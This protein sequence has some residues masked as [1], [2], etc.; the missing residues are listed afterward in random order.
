MKAL[1]LV[2]V[3]LLAGC[4]TYAAVSRHDAPGD[5]PDLDQPVERENGDPAR[6]ATPDDPGSTETWLWAMPYILTRR[7]RGGDG[8]TEAGLEVRVERHRLGAGHDDLDAPT[9]MLS[10]GAGAAQWR[11]GARTI[12]PAAFYAELGLRV[13]AKDAIPVEIG[14]GPVAYV[15]DPDVGGQIT[16]R[17]LLLIPVRIRYMVHSGAEVMVGFQLPVPFFFGSSR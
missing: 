1:I 16:L 3:A 6:H 15:A 10:L 8:A 9:W 11:A 17:V 4:R 2:G 12:A 7:G 14:A 5:V 13:L